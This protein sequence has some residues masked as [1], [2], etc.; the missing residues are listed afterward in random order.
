M[1]IQCQKR[2][3]LA[4]LSA[5][6]RW[7]WNQSINEGVQ[8][9]FRH[10]ADDG[11]RTESLIGVL[12]VVRCT[13]TGRLL[14]CRALNNT[15]NDAPVSLNR[16]SISTW[17]DFQRSWSSRHRR[18]NCNSVCGSH[19]EFRIRWRGVERQPEPSKQ[20]LEPEITPHRVPLRFHGKK[21]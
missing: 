20:R 19:R 6:V 21:S 2:D 7:A 13:A 18:E 8:A 3:V 17:S 12:N 10:A 1:S 14:D 9:P 16:P 4:Q 15:G 11:F 5:G